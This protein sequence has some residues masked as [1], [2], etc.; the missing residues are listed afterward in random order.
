MKIYTFHRKQSFSISL[1]EAWDYFSN[2]LNLGEITPPELSFEIQTANAD[3]VY[4]GMIINYRVKPLPAMRV[5]W[6]SEIKHVREPLQ[7]VDEQRVGPYK[8]WYHLHKFRETGSG[9]EV[10][11]IIYYALSFGV[12]NGAINALVVSKKLEFIFEY[13][14]KVLDERLNRR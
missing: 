13:R 9:V 12:L 6:L 10:E 11:D 2:P 7:F 1:K 4:S 5:N 14:R 3:K 8:M